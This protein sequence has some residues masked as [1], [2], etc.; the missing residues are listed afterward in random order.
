MRRDLQGN[1]QTAAIPEVPCNSRRPERVL[2]D[3]RAIILIGSPQSRG[4]AAPNSV[5]K[6]APD[7]LESH[8]SR[9]SGDAEFL[10][11]AAEGFPPANAE[12][13][14][15]FQAYFWRRASPENSICNSGQSDPSSRPFDRRDSKSACA[16]TAELALPWKARKGSALLALNRAV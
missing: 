11:S 9:A 8:K 1:L 6:N 16:P 14:A 4:G 13:K 5:E 12:L 2:F 10:V 15:G 7:N 3:F